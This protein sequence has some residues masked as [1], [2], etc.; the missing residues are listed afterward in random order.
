MSFVKI[1]AVAAIP[2]TLLSGAAMADEVP[3]VGAM[4]LSQVVAM[5]E[6]QAGTQLAFIKEVDW[7]DDGYWDVEY[8]TTAGDKVELK[9]DPVTGAAR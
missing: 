7:D 9:L 1:F 3:P 5:V 4:K 6:E 8:R 2:A